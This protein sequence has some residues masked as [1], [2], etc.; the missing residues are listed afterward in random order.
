[1]VICSRPSPRGEQHSVVVY[2]FDNDVVYIFNA[3]AAL[4]ISNC[5]SLYDAIGVGHFYILFHWS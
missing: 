2:I 4:F 5:L 1:M 3:N